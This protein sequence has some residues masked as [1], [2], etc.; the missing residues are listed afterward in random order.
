MPSGHENGF[1]SRHNG[2]EDIAFYTVSY[3]SL[4]I[5]FL[6]A[7]IT[8]GCAL[9]PGQ[10]VQFNVNQENRLKAVAIRPF[11]EDSKST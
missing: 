6:Q 5:N 11:L 4:K 3:N 7:D 8:D 1:I 2:K 10:L 9:A